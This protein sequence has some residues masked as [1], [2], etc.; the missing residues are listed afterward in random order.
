ME[1]RRLGK[2]GLQL[3]SL[4]LGSWLTF[5]QQI[6]DKIADE[7]MG[8]AYDAGVNFFDN[9]EGYAEGKSEIVMGK[10]LKAHHWERESY[11][12]SSKV[13]FGTENKGPNRVGLSRKHIIEA[14]NA[15]LK[16]LQVDYL[17]L[18]F[19][20]R[21]DK[22]TPIEETVWAMNTLLQQ[23]KILYWGTS[24]WS[25]SEIMEAIRVARQYN[26]I[27]PTMEQPQ[28]NLIERNKLEN[29]YLLLFKEYGLGTTIWS[30]LASGL[31]SGKYTSGEAKNTRLDMKGLEW[32]K[33]SALAEEKLA[34]VK[35]LQVLADDLNVPLA[36]LSLAWCLKNPNVSTVILG[37]S[38]VEQLKE[39][40]TTLDVLP[41]LTDEVMEN[42]EKVMQTKPVLP[43]F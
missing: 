29:E 16:R 25:A 8:I 31:L 7:L 1:Y 34:K 26:L 22:N 10:I 15:A 42:I 33:E 32:L 2:S 23:G 12:V 9:A 27:G 35:K 38:K 24:E 43:Q 13:F 18:Y 28:Y 37:A 21:P 14:C 6:S 3:S 5:G 40:L 19:C 11:V 20:H 4:S 39:N 30:P 17:D 36:K 41:L